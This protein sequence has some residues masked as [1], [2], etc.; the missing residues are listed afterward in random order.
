MRQGRTALDASYDYVVIGAGTAGSVLASRLSESDAT[1]LLLEAG[2]LAP[3]HEVYAPESF[4]ASLLGSAVDWSFLTTPQCGT[5]GTTHVWSRGK[6]L[7]GSSAINAMAHIRGHKA[8]Y[9][10]WAARGASRWS[11]EDVLPYFKRCETAPGRECAYR[12]TDG[13]L[14]VAPPADL[15]R[16]ALAF[17]QAITQAGHPATAD[18]N[19]RAQSGAFVYDM[20]VVNGRRQSAADAY[21][22]PVLERDNLTVVGGAL[23]HGVGVRQRRC[24]TV[25]FSRGGVAESVA[26]GHEAVIAAGA[27]GS[28]QLLMLSGIGPADELSRLGIAVAADLPGVGQNLQDHVQCRVVYQC[29]RP[30]T[31]APNGF[32]PVGALLRSEL[33]STDEP[34]V[35]LLLID[36]PAGPV[37]TEFPLQSSLPQI[38]YTIAFA[39]QAPP[40]SRGSVRLAG[41]DP[42][43]QPIIDP[44]YYSQSQDLS[45][46]LTYLEM[47]REVGAAEALR[48]WGGTEVMP[49]KR[50]RERTDLLR[51][52]RASSGTSFHPAGTC[53]IGKDALAVVDSDLRVHGVEALRVVDA[54]VMPEIVSANPNATVIAIAE[55]AAERMR[56]G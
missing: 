43:Q 35:L 23:V 19:G 10:G 4:P 56:M 54:S 30:I 17:Q 22:L 53:R 55:L 49:G 50:V 28:P 32:C 9:D 25:Q 45:A 31:S 2:P 37:V 33:A 36:F 7:G 12:G 14:I 5:A 47:A 29:D 51:Y 42:T 15:S 11:Y 34:D 20:N 39:Q 46:M 38:G 40:A 6:V 1:V 21:L 52:V 27:I 44:R 13:P 3:P 24:T 16:D 26:V 18:I 48:P 41:S 8:N